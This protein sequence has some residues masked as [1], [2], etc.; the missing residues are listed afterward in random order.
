M[1]ASGRALSK[2][3]RSVQWST[4][5]PASRSVS[6][7]ARAVRPVYPARGASN[8]GMESYGSIPYHDGVSYVGAWC[9]GCVAGSHKRLPLGFS[10]GDTML[11]RPRI[12]SGRGLEGWMFHQRDDVRLMLHWGSRPPESFFMR[13]LERLDSSLL[14]IA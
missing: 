13:T 10:P 12:S 2:I 9:K 3:G 6:L 8:L 14:I 4:A 1:H 11:C 5:S 7:N